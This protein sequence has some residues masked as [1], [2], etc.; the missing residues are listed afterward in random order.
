MALFGKNDQRGNLKATVKMVEQVIR[1][2]GLDPADN[3]LATEGGGPAWGLMKGSAEVF[4]FINPG[5]PGE[6]GNFIQV[7]SPVLKQPEGPQQHALYHRLLTLNARELTG[8]AFGLKGDT[9]V[10]TTD[11]S[12]IDLDPSEVK[13]MILRIGFYAD[14][15]DD[16]LVNEF[17]GR[18]HSDA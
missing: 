15:Y 1:E 8:A 14:T 4:I 17:G 13:D 6:P 7:V 12:T 2:I 10:L 11:R 5:N 16:A 18:R 9:I 3:Q